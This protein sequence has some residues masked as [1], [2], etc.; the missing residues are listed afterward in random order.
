MKKIFVLFIC[1]TLCGCSTVISDNN[2]SSVS[3]NVAVS[4]YDLSIKESDKNPSYLEGEVIE[5][6]DNDTDITKGGT[7]ILRGSGSGSVTVD[8]D[9][10]NVF[11]VLDNV[12]IETEDFAAIY[13]KEA[14]KATIILE[15]G[16]YLSDDSKYLQRDDNDVDGVIF[17]KADLVI[18]GDGSLNVS[19]SYDKGIVSKDDLIITGGDIEVNAP[20]GKGIEGKDTLKLYN[21]NLNINSNK[22]ALSS[23]NEEDEYRGYVYIESGNININTSGDGIYDG[24]TT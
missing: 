24:G 16:N 18:A 1:L 8:A 7:Y 3:D 21:V 17:S 22:D 2:G 12:N 5:L 6:S 15:G 9:N 19:A 14:D 13:V 23:D 20:N 11:I 4:G 10:D